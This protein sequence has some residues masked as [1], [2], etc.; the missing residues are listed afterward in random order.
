[1]GLAATR[2]VVTSILLIIVTDAVFAGTE[3]F[4]HHAA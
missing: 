2:A 4:L 1:V 3:F